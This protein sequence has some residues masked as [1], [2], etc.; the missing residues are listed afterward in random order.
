MKAFD[1]SQSDVTVSVVSHG[2]G[3]SV[4]TLAIDL[5]ADKSVSKVIVTWNTPEA[6]Q[7]PQNPRLIFIHN[8]AARGFGSN[9]NA[10]FEQCDTRFFCVLNPD[11]TLQTDSIGKLRDFTVLTGAAAA[12]P[13]VLS[14]DGTQEDSWRRFPTFFSL[15]L[16]AFGYDTTVINSI[17]ISTKLQPDWVAGVCIFFD[18]NSFKDVAGFDERFFMYYEDV[19]ICNRLWDA[20]YTVRAVPE[21]HVVHLGRRAS[22]R[23][24]RHMKWHLYSMTRYL[25]GNNSKGRELRHSKTQRRP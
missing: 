15:F 22:R 25:I 11:V 13:L 24:L 12:G 8:K 1:D 9:H 19:D 6:V 20:G 10:A 14:P 16:K 5:L 3:A 18:S 7:L 23:N 17:D 21:A 4:R 2:D